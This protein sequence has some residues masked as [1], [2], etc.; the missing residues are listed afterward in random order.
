[1]WC[2]GGRLAFSI[3]SGYHVTEGDVERAAALEPFLAE[4]P[5]EWIDPPRN[6]EHCISPRH[7]PG[8]F[9]EGAGAP[10]DRDLNE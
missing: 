10:R 2:W 8:W 6:S 5:L 9:T 1:V 3:V 4:L 7:H